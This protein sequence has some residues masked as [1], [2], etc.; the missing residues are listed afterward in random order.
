M[1]VRR[2]YLLKGG[3]LELDKGILTYR[4]DMGKRVKLPASMALVETDDGNILFDTGL[5]RLAFFIFLII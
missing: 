2:L 5:N 3:I 4:V 1:A